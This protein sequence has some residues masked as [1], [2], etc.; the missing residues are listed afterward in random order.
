MKISVITIIIVLSFNLQA[1][2]LDKTIAIV[3]KEIFTLSDAQKIK[4][5]IKARKNISPQ[6][7]SK[8]SYT[9]KEIVQKFIRTQIIRKN[10]EK[11]GFV[12]SNSQVEAQIKQTEITYRLIAKSYYSFSKVTTLLLMNTLILQKK[13]LNLIYFLQGLLNL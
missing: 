9:N 8:S 7:Y 13:L 11:L 4:S 5:N 3:D 10:L 2:L 6:I 12:I 1:K